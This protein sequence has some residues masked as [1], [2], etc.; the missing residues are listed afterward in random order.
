LAGL[1]GGT[2]ADVKPARQR[3]FTLDGLGEPNSGPAMH[4]RLYR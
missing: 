2:G 1:L 4:H 3:W